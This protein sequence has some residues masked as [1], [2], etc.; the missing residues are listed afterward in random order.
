[1]AENSTSAAAG[2]SNTAAE[3][4]TDAQKARI[5]ARHL[6]DAQGQ[7]KSRKASASAGNNS[8][9]SDNV[10]GKLKDAL[11]G[12]KKVE[13]EVLEDQDGEGDE[14]GP[15]ELTVEDFPVSLNYVCCSHHS[16]KL[17]PIDALRNARRRRHARPV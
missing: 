14:S 9:S 12:G 10:M 13:E 7:A 17:G 5:V 2:I 8:K 4:L 1:M 15:K 11:L 3:D 16:L 6:V